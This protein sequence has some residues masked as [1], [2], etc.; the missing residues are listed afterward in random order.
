MANIEQYDSSNFTAAQS[1]A[2][3]DVQAD[4]GT[5]ALTLVLINDG[6]G[7]INLSTSNDGGTSFGPDFQLKAHEDTGERLTGVNQIRLTHTGVDSA[8]RVLGQAGSAHITFSRPS[9]SAIYSPLTPHTELNAGQVQV[10]SGVGILHHLYNTKAQPLTIWNFDGIGPTNADLICNFVLPG[11]AHGH[12][13]FGFPFTKG[14]RID[15]SG[16]GYTVHYE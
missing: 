11:L 9:N 15:S 4:L 7:T 5:I 2:I 3:L 16:M 10:V 1:P 12:V 8:Y 13:E 14:L 6:P